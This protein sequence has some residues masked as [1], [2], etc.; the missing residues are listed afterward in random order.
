[1]NNPITFA[2]ET[3][4]VLKILA[5]EI[6]DSPLALLRENVQ[7]AY[8]AIRMRIFPEQGNLEDGIIRI[9]ISPKSVV[10][11]DNGIGMSETVLRQ[12]FW[13]A[14][15]SGKR[16]SEAAK[17]GVVGT[18]GIG[19]MANF[20]VCT[21]LV[22]ETKT[23]EDSEGIR[24]VAIRN[25]LE[26]GKECISIERFERNEIGT[27]IFVTLDEGQVITVNQ[28]KDYLLPY[29]SFLQVAV[30]LND[31][32]ISQNSYRDSMS[33][34]FSLLGKDRFT[35][36]SFSAEMEISANSNGQI[37]VLISD[38]HISGQ[39]IEGDGAFLQG[40]GQMMALRSR[41]GLAPVPTVG[42]FQFGG[43]VNLPIL[44]PTAGREALG[45]ESV[46]K[47]N[48]IVAI[49]ER[50]ASMALSK[51]SFADINNSFLQWVI[52]H[53]EY[54]LS[55][56]LKIQFLPDNKDVF[57][58]DLEALIG[59]RTVH[60]YAGT[61]QQIIATFSNDNSP[62]LL[63]AQGKPRRTV[64]MH[65]LQNVMEVPQVPDSAQIIK[66]YKNS[67]LSI[68]EV[69]VLLRMVSVI[70]E[71]YLVPDCVAC[72]ADISHGV[73]ILPKMEGDQLT[74]YFSKT[75][76]L[77]PPLLEFSQKAWDVFGAL[78]K[79]FVR[80][81]VYKRIEQYVPSSTRSGVEAL[82][83]LLKQKRELYR[84]EE[85]EYGD[86][87]S[88][89]GDFLSG[90]ATF[91]EVLATATKK[92]KLHS[93]FV[94]YDQV[95]TVENVVGDVVATGEIQIDAEESGPELGPCPPI[96]RDEVLSNLKMLTTNEKYPQLN[97]FSMLLGLSDRMMRTEGDFFRWPHTTRIIWGGHRVVY[98]FTEATGKVS[99]YY[100]IELREA[101]DSTLAGGGLFPTTTLITK[102]RIF[103]PVPD[104][105][106]SAFEIT[107]GAR[108]FFVRY[109][110]LTSDA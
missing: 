68:P 96:I 52:S 23:A 1:M 6:Y 18:F 105:L 14:G 49:A 21:Q 54:I 80:V 61:D 35:D 19:A 3:E 104:L 33:R 64:Q 13:M 88:T 39:P 57:L 92:A 86:L 99:L 20:G 73:T 95:G 43:F 100:D 34:G 75:S 40:G 56:K 30:Y 98:I 109:D 32:L 24:S 58:E 31:E 36:D 65:Y 25:Q 26:I 50:A 69:T 42:V 76:P 4:R 51:S 71:D 9:E 8:D 12:N 47:V 89:L 79:D 46:Q 45:R 85:D 11:S 55:G 10:V 28:A 84:Y 5:N 27:T 87:K 67:D 77:L 103:V 94:R 102:N 41:F 29:V 63:V 15:S 16:T 17:A 110:V 78:M 93:Q 97:N 22:V 66:V 81:H 107:S 62:L 7:N 83:K 72:L 70:R 90:D 106:I 101:L 48:Q 59:G 74:L 60:Y 2:V 108:E 82:S 38:V 91:E 44:K 37:L 53:G